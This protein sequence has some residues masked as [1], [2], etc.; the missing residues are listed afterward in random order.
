MNTIIKAAA[1]SFAAAFAGFV[2]A[3][4][5][6]AASAAPPQAASAA[7][8]S[9]AAIAPAEGATERDVGIEG[10]AAGAGCGAVYSQEASP[11]GP[12]F[13]DPEKDTVARTVVGTDCR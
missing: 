4:A 1:F 11:V 7:S 3:S 12:V 5:Q 8:G 13:G 10:Y 6:T 2:P 9:D